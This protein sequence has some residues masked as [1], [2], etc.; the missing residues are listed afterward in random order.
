MI[1]LFVYGFLIAY[2]LVYGLNALILKCL[3]ILTIRFY[4]L[5]LL[6]I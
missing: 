2:S 4:A 6:N 3:K 1:Y 5:L